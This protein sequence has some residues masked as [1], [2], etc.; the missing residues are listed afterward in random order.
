MN[1]VI[2]ILTT[3]PADERAEEIARVLVDE[4]LAACVNIGAPMISIYRWQGSIAREA[5]SQLVIKT[6]GD[7]VAAVE[8]RLRTLHPYELPE[9]LVMPVGAASQSYAE[10]VSAQTSAPDA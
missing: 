5:E 4:R 10:W 7:R 8:A 6:T 1:E 3:A 9:F 2:L